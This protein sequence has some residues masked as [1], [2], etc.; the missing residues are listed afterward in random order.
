MPESKPV[1]VRAVAVLGILWNAV[2]IYSYLGH[3]GVVQAMGPPPDVAMPMLV[4]AAYAIGVFGAV[5]GCLGLALLQRW[6]RPVLW[7]SFVGLVID[8]GWVFLVSGQWSLA[9]GA[10][11]LIIALALAL[12]ADHASR[13]GWLS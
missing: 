8:W 3:V 10:T 1:W 2:G 6:A 9:L 4:T 12:L 7:V 13:R 5:L 11:V